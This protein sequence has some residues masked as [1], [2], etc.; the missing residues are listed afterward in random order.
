MQ[1]INLI[2]DRVSPNLEGITL[3]LEQ[4]EEAFEGGLGPLTVLPWL[5]YLAL[6][7][8]L[9]RL[10]I[11]LPAAFLLGL[12]VNIGGELKKYL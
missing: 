2:S 3:A 8:S 5:T 1:V 12:A 4:S 9:Y 7:V 10:M 6:P 11:L